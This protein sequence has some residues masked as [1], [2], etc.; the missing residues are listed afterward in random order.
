[1]KIMKGAKDGEKARGYQAEENKRL[2]DEE[3]GNKWGGA[4]AVHMA[5]CL[6]PTHKTKLTVKIR[7]LSISG[8]IVK[9]R[10]ERS[11]CSAVWLLTAARKGSGNNANKTRT[12]RLNNCAFLC[13]KSSKK[14]SQWCKQ[15]RRWLR[16]H[17]H[18]SSS[19]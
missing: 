1:M 15:T 8:T 9:P 11:Q 7:I 5:G 13:D 17:G 2:R 12:C 16:K 14:K 19:I 4:K 6:N 18:C 10:P 3:T